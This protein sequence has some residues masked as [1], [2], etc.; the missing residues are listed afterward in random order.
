MSLTPYFWTVVYDVLIEKSEPKFFNITYIIEIQ[1]KRWVFGI[2][3][4][5]VMFPYESARQEKK[6]STGNFLSGHYP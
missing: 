2:N 6:K 1:Y 5:E 3:I 4:Y